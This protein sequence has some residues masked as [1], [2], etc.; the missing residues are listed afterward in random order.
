MSAFLIMQHK[1]IH[2]N[3]LTIL[4]TLKDNSID[5]WLCDPPYELGFMSQKWD[6]TGIAYNMY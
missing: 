2:G 1:L 4:P 6:S 3:S 5:S